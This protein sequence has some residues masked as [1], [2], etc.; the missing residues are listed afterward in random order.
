MDICSFF[1]YGLHYNIYMVLFIDIIC[2]N[3]FRV[4]NFA[5]YLL[6]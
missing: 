1:M 5:I 3:L 4:Q 2:C 6:E